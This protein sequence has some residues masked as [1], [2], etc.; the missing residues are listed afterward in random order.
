MIPSNGLADLAVEK[1][2]GWGTDYEQS[3]ESCLACSSHMIP[4]ISLLWFSLAKVALLPSMSTVYD[5]VDPSGK[6]NMNRLYFAIDLKSIFQTHQII[7][8]VALNLRYYDLASC[9]VIF[10]S[11]ARALLPDSAATILSRLRICRL[12]NTT[13]RLYT[14]TKQ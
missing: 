8:I 10:C 13:S 3:V 4:Y 14:G 7:A 2:I 9:S 1:L 5:G 6:P 11:Q 12:I